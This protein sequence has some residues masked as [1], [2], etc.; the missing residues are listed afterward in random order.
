MHPREGWTEDRRQYGLSRRGFL[1]QSAAAGL[2][3]GGA[4]SLL[5]ACGSGSPTSGT[6][7]GT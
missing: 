1:K 4:S 3:A 5:A 6:T 7:S 2:L